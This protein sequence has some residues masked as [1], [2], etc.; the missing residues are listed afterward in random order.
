MDRQILFHCRRLANIVGAGPKR[1]ALVGNG[2]NARG[3]GSEIDSHDFVVRMNR[4]IHFGE[5]GTKTDALAVINWSGPGRWMTNGETPINAEA[6]R[7][8]KSIWLPMPPEDMESVKNDQPGTFE[9][10]T[11]VDFTSEVID[12]L[13]DGRPYIKFPP[14]IWRSLTK[15]LRGLGAAKTQASSTGALVLAYLVRVWPRSKVTLYGFTHEGWDGHPW[16]QEKAWI[17]NL[18]RVPYKP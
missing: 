9:W 16:E 2:E 15:E 1:I 12:N 3:F 17:R 10:P 5:A 18:D 8:A 13:V 4:A 11:Y 7:A 14:N 6:L